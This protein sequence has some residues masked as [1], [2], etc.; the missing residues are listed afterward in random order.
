VSTLMQAA[1][2]RFS[3]PAQKAINLRTAQS[4]G[5][6]IVRTIEMA[7][8]SGAVVLQTPEM[9]E[10]LRAI[11]DPNIHGIIAKEFSR[12]IRP[13]N[14]A[15]FY[16]FQAFIDTET[17]LYLP[18]GPIDFNTFEGKLIGSFKA[19]WAG[20]EL[21]QIR[22]RIWDTKE[23]K[24]RAGK[25]GQS[26]ICLPYGVD[27]TESRGWFYKP[28]A[29]R[30]REA[31][32]LLAS[33]ETSYV[34]LSELLGVS[35]PGVKVILQNPVYTGWR[36]IDKRRDPSP[37]ARRH[38]VDGRQADRPKIKR[39]PDE[40]IRVRVIEE[41]LVSEE[42]FFRVQQ[43]IATKRQRHWK[44]RP[45]YQH[46]FTYNS[47]LTCAAC[48]EPVQTGVMRD[49]YYI[50]KGKRKFRLC[51]SSY[52]RRD[53]LDPKLDSLFAERLTDEPFLRS[54]AEEMARNY[55]ANQGAARIVR[56]EAEL[57]RLDAKRNRAIDT[58]IEGRMDKAERDSRLD[59]INLEIKK[60]REMIERHHPPVVLSAQE[61]SALFSPF[62]EWKFL[63][64]DDKH[65]ILSTVIP[66][67]QVADYQVKGLYLALTAGSNNETHV[68]TGSSRPRA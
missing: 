50:C 4:H 63:L 19:L 27:Y 57:E 23:T 34:V 39:A 64:R 55:D 42:E 13:E 17:T 67:I 21:S 44:A 51:S 5:L 41:P 52:M 9:Q 61:L 36:V 40:I 53:V 60:V 1:D 58:Y 46:R 24:R 26:K 14:L 38:T 15:D 22:E 45:D 37:S 7:D 68:G 3:I 10:L 25:F 30:V 43:I 65:R 49:D 11:A 8:V 66:E 35:S 29:E 56:L 54:L 33:G 28:E 48:G 32:R 18:E 47:F 31:F 20:R 16:L 62:L 59:A 6:E 12:L 2:D